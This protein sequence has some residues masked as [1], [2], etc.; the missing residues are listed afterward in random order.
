MLVAK[1]IKKKAQTS[2]TCMTS[3]GWLV[4]KIKLNINVKT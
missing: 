4:Y 2:Y 1:A 3:I